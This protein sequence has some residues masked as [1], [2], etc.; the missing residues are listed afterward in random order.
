MITFAIFTALCSN[1]KLSVSAYKTVSFLIICFLAV[2]CWQRKNEADRK[3]A[4]PE[5]KMID[6]ITEL[7]LTDGLL[8]MPVVHHWYEMKDSISAY[9]DVISKHGYSKEDFDRTL[10]FYFIKRPKQLMK[11]Y[12]QALAR[13]SEMESRYDQMAQQ[14]QAKISNYWKGR[15]FYSAPGPE[16]SDSTAFDIKLDFSNIYYLSFTA[17]VLPEDETVNSR[18]VIYTCHA[19]SALTGTRYYVRTI[20]FIKDGQ[21]HRYVYQIKDSL[22]TRLRLM[23]NLFAAGNDPS[24]KKYFSIQDISL[25]Y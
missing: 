4:I 14:M 17:T 10:R 24:L 9:R 19:D 15:P 3:N 7:Y 12:E 8:I 23:G 21:P 25:T 20:D 16:G 13:L 5:D 22:K 2:S 18:P 1:M 6:I 11:M